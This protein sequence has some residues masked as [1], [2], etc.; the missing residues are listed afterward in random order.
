MP[1]YNSPRLFIAGDSVVSMKIYENKAAAESAVKKLLEAQLKK[2]L[3]KSVQHIKLEEQQ[4]NTEGNKQKLS[5]GRDIYFEQPDLPEYFKKNNKAI[6]IVEKCFKEKWNLFKE[7]KILSDKFHE[8]FADDCVKKLYKDKC[9]LFYQGSS[10]LVFY[11]DDQ[12]IR[13]LKPNVDSKEGLNVKA[14]ENLRIIGADNQFYN[15]RTF[16]F[17]QNHSSQKLVLRLIDIKEDKIIGGGRES[18]LVVYEKDKGASVSQK[19]YE[20]FNKII[21]ET[22]TTKNRHSIT[23][24]PTKINLGS[25]IYRLQEVVSKTEGLRSCHL[26]IVDIDKNSVIN[27][28]VK[29]NTLDPIDEAFLANGE[30]AELLVKT[31]LSTNYHLKALFTG[32]LRTLFTNLWTAVLFIAI[33]VIFFIAGAVTYSPMLVIGGFLVL[34]F[35]L[36]V[37]A[38]RNGKATDQLIKETKPTKE[39]G[40]V[41]LT[42]LESSCDL[43][44]SSEK[45]ACLSKQMLSNEKPSKQLSTDKTPSKNKKRLRYK[46]K[47][48]EEEQFELSSN[49]NHLSEPSDW[50]SSNPFRVSVKNALFDKNKEHS[51]Q[52]ENQ[53]K[54]IKENSILKK[55][56]KICRYLKGLYVRSKINQE[57]EKPLNTNPFEQVDLEPN[58]KQQTRKTMSAINPFDEVPDLKSI[59]N[60]KNIIQSS[61]NFFTEK[62]DKC[63]NSEIPK[64]ILAFKKET[65]DKFLFFNWFK[66]KTNKKNHVPDLPAECSPVNAAVCQGG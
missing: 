39:F 9:G 66:N 56:K 62:S 7:K 45:S 35:G 64:K 49:V 36:V 21:E 14:N 20:V 42:E 28:T 18:I 44:L 48:K 1:R 52:Q 10:T 17:C 37:I 29:R 50:D 33:S 32:L 54:K 27:C 57:S 19:I 55:L 47:P 26:Y 59:I 4:E 43:D 16:A 8:E 25:A 40:E 46:C 34:I 30:M 41:I 60:S 12:Y 51:S 6:K 61:K 22:N 5:H 38:R 65:K 15:G 23:N 3:I 2:V 24:R 53:D 63:N 11:Q 58:V 13:A 31:K